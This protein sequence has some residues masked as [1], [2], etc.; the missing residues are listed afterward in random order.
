MPESPRSPLIRPTHGYHVYGWML[1]LGLRGLE[2]NLYAIIHTFTAKG[3]TVGKI[4]Y[5]EAWTGAKSTAIKS[6]LK[7]L[8][9]RGLIIA[10]K[11]K[12]NSTFYSVPA[13]REEPTK[14]DEKRPERQSE[15]DPQSD[16]IRLTQKKDNQKEIQ[17]ERELMNFTPTKEQM[18]ATI[19]ALNLGFSEQE[20]NACADK[21]LDT[22]MANGWTNRNGQPIRVWQAHLRNYARAWAE[23]NAKAAAHAASNRKPSTSS[24]NE[25]IASEYR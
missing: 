10:S 25:Q 18:L 17:S 15:S 11:G 13:T 24:Y 2:L 12:G 19:T 1:E 16:G 4:A 9:E 23:N 21:W 6:A 22:C 3:G 20:M 5:F 7:T 14:R 8:K